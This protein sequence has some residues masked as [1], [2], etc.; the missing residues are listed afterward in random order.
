M[1]LLDER[2]LARVLTIPEN[3]TADLADSR[4]VTL[5]LVNHPDANAEETEAV[6]LVI[7]GVARDMSLESQILAS[8]RRM[9]EMQASAPEERQVFVAER[10][11]AQARSQ[12]E[13]S[14]TQ[15]LVELV[16]LL[17]EREGEREEMPLYLDQ[18]YAIAKPFMVL[19]MGV[20]IAFP[21]SNFAQSDNNYY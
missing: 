15:P 11:L 20:T 12:F 8:L 3:F 7:E 21:V 9:G 4:Q 13:R 6:Q 19:I 14:R 5:R 2:K 1:A 17:P 18:T 10:T 16:Q